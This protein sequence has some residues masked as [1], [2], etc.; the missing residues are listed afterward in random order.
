VS[1]FVKAY[2]RERPGAAVKVVDFAAGAPTADLLIEETLRDPGCVEVGRPDD[3]LRWS[4]GLAEAPFGDGR[5]GLTPDKDTVFV[6]TGAAGSIVSAIVGDLAKASGATFHLLDLTPQPDPDDASLGKFTTDKDGLKTDIAQRLKDSGTRPTPVLIEREL[7]RYER[8]TAALN[9][10]DAVTKA[11]GTAH[12]HQVDLTDTTAVE[13]VMT[14]VRD[15]SGRVDV[16]LH[17]AG[18]DISRSLRDKTRMEYDL[19][20]DVKS[21]GW[22]N[23]LRA[24]GDMPLGVTVAFSSVAGRFGNLG[25]TDYSAANDL[26]CK[27]TSS[28]R[29]TRPDTRALVLDWTAWGGFGMATRGSIPKAMAAAGIEMLAPESGISWIRR[30]LTNSSGRGEVVVGGELGVLVEEFDESG[31][32]DVARVST[33]GPMVGTVETAG[34]YRGL[35]VHTTLD[36]TQQPFLNDHRIDG[37][38]VLP[39]VMGIEAFAE[40]ARL[41]VPDWHVA[42]VENVDFLAP[43]KFYRDEPR[44]LTIR[45]TLTPDRGDVVAA[46]VL[47]AD[48]KLPG[49]DEPQRTTHFTGSVRLTAQAPEPQRAEVVR[50][51]ASTVPRE[52]VY[53]L[54]FHGPAYQ[55]VAASWPHDGGYA[56]RLTDPLPDN[57]VPAQAPTY[58]APR[59]IELCFQAAGL[60][61]AAGT[62]RLALPQH[63]DR[64]RVP[65]DPAHIEGPVYAA[66]TGTDGHA[67]CLVRD[68]RGEV[69]VALEGYRTSPLPAPVPDDVREGLRPRVMR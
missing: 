1:G 19:V 4:I 35:V 57:H 43:V 56:A 50:E 21:D 55:V 40:V 28:L 39:G 51:P 10:I 69:L 32:L 15:T 46:C 23:L 65:R 60:D 17:A 3:G 2:Q 58:T 7:A 61:E 45:A 62:G 53:D 31:G 9:A 67:D 48:R 29:R 22:F 42:A 5:D 30:E 66:T 64:V 37:T 59:L 63:V 6:V 49:S 24:I 33:D 47:E 14:D 12:Y 36:P 18:L 26:L 11:G 52:R 13:Q 34:V 16:L 41:L 20:F 54:Y 44:T 68:S 38:A 27:I 8:L 25:Q